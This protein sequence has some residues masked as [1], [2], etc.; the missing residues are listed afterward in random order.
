MP[1]V[2]QG[3]QVPATAQAMLAA[4]ID[5]LAPEDKRLLQA[6]AVIGTDVPFALLQALADEPEDRLRRRL[7]QLQATEFLYET[8]LFPDLEYAFK[9]ALTHEVAYGSLLQD[10][11]RALHS[12]I[13]QTV[14]RLHPD[15]LAE[16]V[17]RLAH[18]AFRGELWE[19]S[20]TYL[21]Q[22][23]AKAAERSAHRE[24]V[25]CFEQA[26]MALAY[27]PETRETLE[28]AIDLRLDLR[29]SLF[30]LAELGRIE[31]YL[32]EADALARRLDDQRRLGWVLVYACNLHMGTGGHLPEVRTFAQ[33]VQA[34]GDALG[35]VA[36]QVT[37][38]YYLAYVCHMSADY[39]G[40][41]DASR[42]L[43]QSL[44]GDQI[45]Q[46]FGLVHFPAV[47]VR[48]QLAS[49]LAERGA[50]DEADAYS[51]EAIRIAEA[52][53]HPFSLIWACWSLAYINSVKG[54]L[55]QAARLLERAVALCH[56][57]NITIWTPIVM[58]SLG[59]VYAW[60]GRIGEGVALLQQALAAYESAGIGYF[61]SLSVAQLGAAHLLADRVEDARTCA[62][63]AVMLT[64]ERGEHGYEAWV[65]RLLGEIASHSDPPD[66]ETARGHYRQAL[67]L[68]NELGMRPL[69]AHCHLGL[70]KLCQRTGK[71][72]EAQE[73]LTTATT[74][75]REMDMRFWLEQG[76]AEM[77]VVA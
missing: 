53:D 42:R 54:E 10:R 16:H 60:S 75:Y 12:Q 43:I 21:R 26:L 67:A 17:E 71:R 57:R 65:L 23:G 25:G 1:R 20:V 19:K 24:A 13:V 59:H 14:E 31:G 4:R 48:A 76:E 58:A 37:G 11:R 49:A 7:A 47:T 46:R 50:F 9:H 36:L 68:A 55:S 6:A 73:H 69:V 72:Q 63:R 39:Q 3:L 8:R 41:D 74:M 44:Q 2:V 56:D 28:Q 32:R 22:A 40:I 18:H 52:L 70:G 62:D 27:L 61:H 45:R 5:R 66:V 34:I 33:R 38:Q 29:K 35:D 51:Q 15:R 77:S 30:P 64:R